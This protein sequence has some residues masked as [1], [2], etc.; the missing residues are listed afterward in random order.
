MDT[1]HVIARIDDR[2]RQRDSNATPNDELR[3]GQGK[4]NEP[5]PRTRQNVVHERGTM[6]PAYELETD[7]RE[8]SARHL[9]H[10]KD[11]E[12]NKERELDCLNGAPSVRAVIGGHFRTVL[13]DTGS[14]ISLIKPGV[15]KTKISRTSV[16]PFG[17]TGD[18]L[19]VEGEQS[20]IITING[21]I[22]YP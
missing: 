22:I 15:S 8:D 12:R 13:V 3:I 4:V 11:A 7:G 20:V 5:N 16:T 2:D 21:E 14:S 1:L 19:R 10:S 6:E 9:C 17:V 18:E